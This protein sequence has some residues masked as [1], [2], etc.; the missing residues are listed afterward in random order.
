M[1]TVDERATH[2]TATGNPVGLPDLAS[3]DP[4][5]R[6][7]HLVNVNVLEES[8]DN[9][10]AE[11]ARTFN[12]LCENIRQAGFNEPILICPKR[13]EAM[14]ALPPPGGYVDI[15]RWEIISGHERVRAAKAVGITHVPA[16][17]AP[18]FDDDM[19][20]FQIVRMNVIRGKI[21]P[22]KF[23]KVYQAACAK[24]TEEIARTMFMFSD[25]AALDELIATV[26][27]ALPGQ[28]R[29]AVDQKK[30]QIKTIDDLASIVSEIFNRAGSTLDRGFAVFSYG[31]QTHIY[32]AMDKEL[33]A[34]MDALVQKSDIE[35]RHISELLN[36]VLSIEV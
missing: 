36:E 33:K 23:F 26:K 7:V 35:N 12:N 15:G 24:Y 30:G 14:P 11:D 20:R 29:E 5:V 17:I 10:T 1:K 9:V 27:K 28:M 22:V 18:E 19:R 6:P 16:C 8:P 25:G 4:L 21:S 34:K 32:V 13:G 2:A 31:G 3:T